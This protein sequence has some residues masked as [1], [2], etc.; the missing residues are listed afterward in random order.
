MKRNWPVFKTTLLWAFDRITQMNTVDS[1]NNENLWLIFVET[2]IE[3]STNNYCII[4]E[5]R[6]VTQW[7]IKSFQKN[8]R[9]LLLLIDKFKMQKNSKL[10]RKIIF[11]T[12]L[13]LQKHIPTHAK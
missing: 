6:T 11:H 13:E 10:K 2:V 1:T 12:T 5:N 9:G 7:I 3:I 4:S 8:V